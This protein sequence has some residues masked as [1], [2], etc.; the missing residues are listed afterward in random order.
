MQDTAPRSLMAGGVGHLT[1]RGGGG[2]AALAGAITPLPPQPHVPLTAM[3][4]KNVCSPKDFR[5]SFH[6]QKQAEAGRECCNRGNVRLC[7]RKMDNSSWI[8][9]KY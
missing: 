7:R 4:D 6:K 2:A 3:G 5:A 8:I 1:S 9:S